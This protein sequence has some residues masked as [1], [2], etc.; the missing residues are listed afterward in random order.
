MSTQ[1]THSILGF[2]PQS[3]LISVACSGPWQTAVS[4]KYISESRDQTSGRAPEVNPRSGAGLTDRMEI[5]LRVSRVQGL[6]L[7]RVRAWHKGPS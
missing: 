3:R 7:T 2:L 1:L 4:G 6:Q 5:D